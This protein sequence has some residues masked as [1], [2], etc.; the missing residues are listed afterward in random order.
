MKSPKKKHISMWVLTIFMGLSAVVFFPSVSS[1]IAVIF[2]LIAAPVAPLQDFLSAHGVGGKVKVV[3]L[4]AIFLS[5][6][7][8]AKAAAIRYSDH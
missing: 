3:L 5:G 4:V 2:V 8:R 7:Y 1:I 6:P